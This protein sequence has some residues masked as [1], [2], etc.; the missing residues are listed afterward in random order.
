M[1][2]R[3]PTIKAPASAGPRMEPLESRI[4]ASVSLISE[5]FEG[6]FPSGGWAVNTNQSRAW[7]DGSRRA[8][9]GSWSGFCAE[10]N[11]NNASATYVNNM[12]T[13]MQRTVSLAGYSTAALS[14]YYW[15]NTESGYDPLVVKINGTEVWRQSGSRQSWNQATINLDRYA[16]QSNVTVRFEFL[17]D[18]SVV[19][20]GDAGV[21]LDDILLTAD[22]PTQTGDTDD[23]ISEAPQLGTIT[24]ARTRTGS[25]SPGTDVDML[26]FDVAAAGA[27]QFDVD[28]NFDSYLRLFDSRGRELTRNDDAAAPGETGGLDAYLRYNFAGGGRYYVGVSGYGNSSY[29][30]VTG[31]GDGTGRTGDYSL[32]ITPVVVQPSVRLTSVAWG[33]ANQVSMREDG[34]DAWENDSFMS[35]GDRYIPSGLSSPVWRDANLD[36]DVID[37]GDVLEPV[38]YVRN[39]SP[40]LR[41]SLNVS[42]TT[43]GSVRVRAVS[44]DAGTPLT[45]TGTGT[46]RGG[47]VTVDLTAGQTVGSTVQDRQ[48]NLRWETSFDGGATYQTIG[49][50]STELFV[51]YGS[52]VNASG[53]TV[54]A[55]RVNYAV[56]HAGNASSILG[57]A[58]AMARD[59]MNRFDY[60]YFYMNEDGWSVIYTGG[61]CGSCSWLE[62]NALNVLGV[63]GEVRY[64]FARHASWNGLWS[65]DPSAGERDAYGNRLCYMDAS[66]SGNNYEGCCFV[67]DGTSRRYYLGGYGGHYETSAYNV[68]TYV[69]GPNV[70]G[71]GAH[72]FWSNNWYQPISFPAGTPS[73]TVETYGRA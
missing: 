66:G 54:T 39:S 69:A 4:L 24:S 46:V 36:G 52:P 61:D 50:T 64:V 58:D 33:G 40:T 5:G 25:V 67:A 31:A 71:S 6:V 12:D 20:S 29:D 32:I 1:N 45:F 42:G 68:L 16:G 21:W 11:N 73:P 62:V 56:D 55:A 10:Y 41:A 30:A 13:Y 34:A 2:R 7:D 27:V 37:I 38:A 17:S 23:Q 19:P 22:T 48:V 44:T 8:H 35:D 72:Q 49:T 70:S 3:A 47:T 51:L 15:M 43:S 59:A 63:A 26:G 9:S 57:I 53:N 60:D 65:R 14:F 28:S 18:G